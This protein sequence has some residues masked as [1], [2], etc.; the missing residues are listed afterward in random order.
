MH[1]LLPCKA[2]YVL[3]FCFPCVKLADGV[4]MAL[5]SSIDKFIPIARYLGHYGDIC[6]IIDTK[7]VPQKAYIINYFCAR[8]ARITVL[9]FSKIF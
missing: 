7:H 1:L 4:K 6:Y 3:F 2:Q 9:Y 8:L 5:M